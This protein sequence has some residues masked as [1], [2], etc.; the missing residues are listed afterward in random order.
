MGEAPAGRPAANRP[1]AP[2]H[3]AANRPD[4]PA[5]PA[6]AAVPVIPPD[7]A[8]LEDLS[9][10]ESLSD[11]ADLVDLC[12]GKRLAALTGAG[13]STG[14]G[15]PDYRGTGSSGM[16]TVDIDLFLSDPM[17]RRWVWQR[18][19]ETWRALQ[20]LPP[21]RGHLALAQ[22]EGA[23]MLEGVATQNVD[24][25]HQR[26]GSRRV[27]ELHGSFM[28]VD[29]LGCGHQFPRDWL[30]ARLREAN[31][32]LVDDP[33]P[34]HVAILAG[35][36]PEGARASRLTLVDCPDCGGLLKPD[37]V[38]FGES[39]P[40][41]ALSDAFAMADSCDVLLVVGT[42]VK[43][44]TAVWVAGQAASSGAALVVINRGPTD[45]DHDPGVAL[46]IEGDC[47]VYLPALAHA[48]G[49]TA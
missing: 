3:P 22:L 48:L 42:S 11:L 26:A 30:D 19:Q 23:G 46:R 6:H 45:L 27:A 2:A 39:L 32:W 9:D 28:L 33:D 16:P 31:P 1:D 44:S 43:V 4:A 7:P 13:L 29:C 47:G 36:D 18:N 37:V 35:V 8:D 5:H 20:T 40:Q 21:T 25:L 41:A 10:L 49:A 24:G 38:F 14:S 15:L 34:A 17:W 12:R